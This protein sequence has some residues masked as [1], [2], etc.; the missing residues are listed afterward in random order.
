MQLT[1]RYGENQAA[2]EIRFL[3]KENTGTSLG[4]VC[5]MLCRHLVPGA[6]A[7]EVIKEV[8]TETSLPMTQMAESIRTCIDLI[9]H[10]FTCSMLGL[11]RLAP[12]RLMRKSSL[13]AAATDG[14]GSLVYMKAWSLLRNNSIGSIIRLNKSKN[15]KQK[16]RNET[17]QQC[18][19]GNSGRNYHVCGGL[20]YPGTPH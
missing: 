8:L 3:Q 1:Q 16:T 7:T 13:M 12:L 10:M 14:Q 6:E 2:R 17:M 18:S 5:G 15:C 19:I 4:L 20:S 9:H 11:Q